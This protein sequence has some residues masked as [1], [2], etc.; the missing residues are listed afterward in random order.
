MFKGEH[1][2][3][4]W[5]V[6]LPVIIA[7]ISN[8][9]IG[10][11]FDKVVYDSDDGITDLGTGIKTTQDYL[12]VLIF[13]YLIPLLMILLANF[14]FMR[15]RREV[16]DPLIKKRILFFILGFTFIIFG[17]LVFV[18]NSI[19]DEFWLI[20]SW[21]IVFWIFGTLFWVIGPILQ[22]IGFNLGKISLSGEGTNS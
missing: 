9:L 15:T 18:L 12:W 17:V 19:V 2:L 7:M 21:E 13:L 10:A 14:Y 11:V 22:I 6:N 20:G 5:Y 1:Y 3:K 4:K 16:E 8:T